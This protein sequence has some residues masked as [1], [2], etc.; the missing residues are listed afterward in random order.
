MKN[1][2]ITNFDNKSLNNSNPLEEVLRE[3]A[4]K[5]LQAAIE[6]EVLEFIENHKTIKD[7][8]GHRLVIRNG[9]LP[10]RNIQSGIG[11]IKIK[12]PR[13]RDKSKN[14]KFTSSILPRYM[15]KCPSLENLIPI[16]YLKGI[17]TSSFQEALES[18]LGDK[19]KG[20][21]PANIVRL[22]KSWELEYKDW[23]KRDLSNKYYIYLWADGIFFNVRLDKD[24]P[25][26][27]III[28][29]RSNGKKELVAIHDGYRESKLSWKEVLQDLKNRGMNKSPLLA[30][31]DGAL[32]F[33]SALEEEFPETKHQR[34]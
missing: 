15:K 18:I 2:M 25:C 32:G 7:K 4:K 17:S 19:A 31:G 12:Q 3:G 20:L 11:N 27:L 34:C 22:K 21:S 30:T 23:G 28:G 26:L 9:Y 33:W 29:V 24:R 14:I 13:I 10:E 1:N 5:M 16:L 6:N 8:K